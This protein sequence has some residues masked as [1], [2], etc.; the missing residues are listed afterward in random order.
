MPQSIVKNTRPLPPKPSDIRSKLEPEPK[1][2]PK[3]SSPT[4]TT[5]I[6]PSHFHEHLDPNSP[7]L[8]YLPS[9]NPQTR[10]KDPIPH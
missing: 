3:L 7:S 5:D 8:S 6:R 10:P 4:I 9:Y 2:K 1:P